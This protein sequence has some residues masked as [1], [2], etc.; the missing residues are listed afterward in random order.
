MK[1]GELEDLVY[2]GA[3]ELG[4]QLESHCAI[5]HTRWATHGP[6]HTKNSPGYKYRLT[7]PAVTLR[8]LSDRPIS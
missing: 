7:N 2:A 6:P 8:Q 3:Q 5:A 4:A 1:V